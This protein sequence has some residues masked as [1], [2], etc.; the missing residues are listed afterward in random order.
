MRKFAITLALLIFA[1]VQVVLAQTTVTGT[2]TSSEDSKGIPGATVLVKGTTVGLTT[3]MNGKYAI[4]V[5][6]NGKVLQFSFVG[7]KT[8]EVTIG[9]QTTIDVVLDPD[10]MDIE[11]VVVT[12]IGIS[13]ETKALGYAVESVTGDELTRSGETNVVQGLASKAAGVQVIGSGGTPGASSKILIRGNSTFTSNNQPLI[14]VD[15]VPID[16]STN[17]TNAGDNPFNI[18]LEGVNN[19]NR[20]LDINPDDIESVTILKGPAAAALYGVRAGNGA[21]IYTTKRGKASQGIR[22]T[23]GF[24]MDFSSISKLPEQQSIY[25]QGNGGGAVDAEGNPVP[26]GTFATAD[27][28]P[29]FVWNNDDDISGGT[30]NSWGP[31]IASLGLTPVNNAEN[32]FQNA[33]TLTHNLQIAGG[34]DITSFR[35]S[36]SHLN[37][38]GIIPNTELNKTTVRL[39]ADHKLSS[40]IKVGGT[41]NYSNTNGIKAQNGSNLSG[42]M[43]SLMRAPQ[44]F[45]MNPGGGDNYMYPNGVDRRFISI[46]DNT[47]YTAYKNP[48]TDDVNRFMGNFYIDYQPFTWLSATYRLGTDFYSDQRKQ[49]FA[50]GS[51][52][53]AEPTGQIT[54]NIQRFREMYSDL[55]ITATHE[56]SS[57]F[58]GS[59]S[60]GN[61]LNER[62]FQDLYARGTSL[63]IPNFY[64]LSNAAVLYASEVTTKERTAALFF[65]LNLDYKNMIYFSATGRNEWASTFGPNQN[66]FFYP[67][68]S[69]SFVFTEL[70]PENNILSFGKARL[71]WAQVGINPSPYSSRTYFASPIFTD[72][73]T[74]GLSFPYLGKGG[75]GYSATLGNADLKPERKTGTELGLDLRFFTGRLTVDFT[76][77]NEESD[78]ILVNRPIAPSSG[79]Q[80]I[81]ANSGRMVNKGIELVVSGD[82]IKTKDFKWNIAVNFTKN[83]NEV[84][85]LAPGVDEVNI[86]S[87]FTSIGSYAIV[88]DA[89][90]ALYGTKWLRNDNGDLI[91]GAN[92]RPSIAPERG[93]IGNPFPDWT[94]GI[95]NGFN[96]KGINL[97]FLIDIRE[98]G[99]IW[100]GTL[101]RMHRIGK[102]EESGNRDQTYIIPGVKADGTP[103][104][105]PIS[106]NS[107]FSNYVGDGGSAAV[108]QAVFDGS[109]VRLRE[110]SLS[111]RL[112]TKD[113]MPLLQYVDLTL[114][115]RN[116][117]LST[118]YPGVDPETS[119]T[120]AGS[121]L[122]GFDYFNNPGTKSFIV[123]IKV[124][125]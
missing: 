21:I 16:N 125:F 38:E 110:V 2:V 121:N 44:S 45:D 61:N 27:P 62:N 42:I 9:S 64:N 78:Q 114:S 71:S 47:Y 98:G 118:D 56:F 40:K 11:G 88:G 112:N 26:E 86:E 17:A 89:Y 33:T 100:N 80:Q 101:A 48:F 72:G 116:L 4:K 39:T 108:E 113:K 96:Y 120:G 34:D 24:N 31:T 51:M 119:L 30:A 106:A 23:Y 59:L 92:G 87:A 74:N 13:R 83:T 99:M 20:A 54:E 19:S 10:V 81:V 84:L 85:E 1:G 8:R 49:I 7:M 77:Y 35:L 102:T 109:W 29:D 124:G 12:A 3:D 14:V 90:G 25:A 94:M 32:F 76:Y 91:I 57:D 63:S 50:I 123:G 53:P 5:P 15:G 97:S 111:Y 58:K 65:D 55:V 115:G 6:S 105:I 70:I 107:Y 104:D 122:T 117:W 67:S 82:P 37:N 66:N 69:L 43:L 60:L 93:N 73:F 68:T 28:G 46:Y 95:T 75:F 41:A 22:V 36:L 103:N 18:G 79:F 52:Q